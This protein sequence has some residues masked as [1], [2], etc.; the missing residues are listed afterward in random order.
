[1]ILSNTLCGVIE[2]HFYFFRCKVTNK[3]AKRK[4]CSNIFSGF[5]LLFV[6]GKEEWKNLLIIY[7]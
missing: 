1:M 2:V 3:Q 7:I 6:C 5:R 4:A